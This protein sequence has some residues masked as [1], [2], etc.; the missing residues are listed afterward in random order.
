VNIFDAIL[1]AIDDCYY[2]D[3]GL[4]LPFDNSEEIEKA[5]KLVEQLRDQITLF[6][7]GAC[8]AEQ[9]AENNIGKIYCNAQMLSYQRILNM[10]V[11][12]D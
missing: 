10:E 8:N 7:A 6:E 9:R 2:F 4:K 12:N 3:S 5:K 1:K 11:E